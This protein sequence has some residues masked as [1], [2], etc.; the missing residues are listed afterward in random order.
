MIPKDCGGCTCLEKCCSPNRTDDPYCPNCV[1]ADWGCLTTQAQSGLGQNPAH[2]ATFNDFGVAGNSGFCK[3]Q[4]PVP[5]QNKSSAYASR[6]LSSGRV[7]SGVGLSQAQFQAM[8]GSGHAD[9]SIACG[10][11]LEVTGRMAKWD[12]DLTEP[13]DRND[14]SKWPYH[15]VIAMVIDQCKDDWDRYDGSTPG[16]NC[17]TGHLDFDVYPTS[18]QFGD[19][20]MKDVTWRAVDCPSDGLPLQFAFASTVHSQ[21]FFSVLVWDMRSPIKSME[22]EAVCSNGTRAW[23][24][25]LFQS[26]GWTYQATKVCEDFVSDWPNLKFRLTSVYDE[27]LIQDVVVPVDTWT[28]IPNWIA[29]PPVQG[30]ANFEE[31]HAPASPEANALY[32]HCLS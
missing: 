7:F 2:A 11:C 3:Y 5:G 20:N 15:K 18:H 14:S 24:S 17:A 9:G 32:T 4:A 1:G 23:S 30:T 25:M 8:V 16:G 28:Q 6:L 22:V 12:C 27:V 13:V 31:S 29:W 10:M 26:L 21:W 19:L